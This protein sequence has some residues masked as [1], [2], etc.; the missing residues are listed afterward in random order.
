MSLISNSLMLGI[1]KGL[2]LRDR[3]LSILQAYCIRMIR[4]N[5]ERNLDL[6]NNTFSVVLLFMI[7]LNDLKE[8]IL[9]GINLLKRIR[10]NLMIHIQQ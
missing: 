10:C 5:K 3:K 7:L 2:W 4:P 6:N 9:L 8:I 1:I